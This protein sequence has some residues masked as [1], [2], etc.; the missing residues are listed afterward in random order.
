MMFD[1]LNGNHK[2]SGSIWDIATLPI[3]NWKPV[4]PSNKVE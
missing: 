4:L 2:N 3:R 1:A